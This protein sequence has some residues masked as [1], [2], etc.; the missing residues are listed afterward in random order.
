MNVNMS[1]ARDP[2]PAQRADNHGAG[3]PAE[4]RKWRASQRPARIGALASR[5]D[6]RRRRD[7][8]QLRTA[9]TR[10]D[11][12]APKGGHRTDLAQLSIPVCR[13]S[14]PPALGDLRAPPRTNERNHFLPPYQPPPHAEP[15]VRTV[16][17]PRAPACPRDFKTRVPHR[18][19]A[20]PHAN[21]ALPPARL[22]LHP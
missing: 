6:A 22:T 13:P 17:F 11:V 12:P 8:A 20:P 2:F 5:Q 15:P 10:H 19:P 9:P 1:R 4:M 18:A 3:A 21:L 14:C 7:F 16:Q